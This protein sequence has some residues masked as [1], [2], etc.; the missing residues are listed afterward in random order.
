MAEFW[1]YESSLFRIDDCPIL[2]DLST[3]FSVFAFVEVDLWNKDTDRLLCFNLRLE[4][5]MPIWFL[6]IAVKIV[7]GYPF[8]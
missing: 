3:P 2:A 7:N 8:L 1:E 5:D 4:E 6:D